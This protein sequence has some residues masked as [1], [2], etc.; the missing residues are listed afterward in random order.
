[1]NKKILILINFL[2]ALEVTLIIGAIYGILDY[3]LADYPYYLRLCFMVIISHMY[4]KLIINRK[5]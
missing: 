2:Q 3:F 1:M 4:N 5:G